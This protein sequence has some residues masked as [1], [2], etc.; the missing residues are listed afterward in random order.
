LLID[1]DRILP[2]S[3]AAQGFKAV[4][5]KTREIGEGDGRVEYFPPFPALPVKA[6]ERPHE[7]AFCEKLC[8]FVPKAEGAQRTNLTGLTMYVKRK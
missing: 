8:A 6:L 5:R 7:F 2:S 1:A 4:A 3:V